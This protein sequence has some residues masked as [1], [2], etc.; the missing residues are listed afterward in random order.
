MLQLVVC[1]VWCVVCG[2]W[3]V[4]CGVW[5]VVWW[6]GGVVVWWCGGVV[7][8]VWWVV[9]GVVCGVWWVVG[10][11]WCGVWCEYVH[12]CACTCMLAYL[13]RITFNCKTIIPIT[14]TQE[15]EDTC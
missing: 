7:C 2:V 6:C 5:C 10:G 1:G 8:G 3:C 14:V 13:K 9:C 12:V 11:G 15:Q 4:V